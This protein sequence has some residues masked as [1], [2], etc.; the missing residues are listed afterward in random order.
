MENA[1]RQILDFTKGD[2]GSHIIK[3]L[4]PEFVSCDVEK[5]EVTIK[6]HVEQWQLNPQKVMHG[7]IICT[8]FDNTFALLTHYYA[9]DAFITTIDLNTKFLKPI[10]EHSDLYIKAKACSVGKTL[11]SL[12]AE[13]YLKETNAIAATSTATFMILQ[14][15]KTQV[16]F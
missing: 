6:V 5:R 7:G 16:K 14:G 15:K 4:A 10:K 13:A 8:A 1:I 9:K 11:I 12:T 2:E 3:M